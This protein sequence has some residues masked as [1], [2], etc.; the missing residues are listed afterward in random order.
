MARPPP[1]SDALST[2]AVD[3]LFLRARDAALAVSVFSSDD[4]KL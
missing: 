2:V 1:T 3:K 4:D